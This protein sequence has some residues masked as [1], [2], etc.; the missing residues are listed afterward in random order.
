VLLMAGSGATLR[1]L[2][3]L[4]HADLGY[5]AQNL[6]SVN[7]V[8]REG[9]HD[10]WADRVQYY[11]QIRDAVRG[12]PNVVSAAI[13]FLPPGIFA[14]TPVSVPGLKGASGQAVP[15][16][17]SPEYFAT[18]HIPLLL[19]RTWT[20][21]EAA[22][23]ARLALINQSMRHRYWPD[24]NP[25]GQVFVLNNG[26][27]NANAWK[28]VAPG[29]NQHYQVIGVV[30]DTPN[31]GLDEA[32]APG[33]YIPYSMTAYDGFNI[34]VRSR[35]DPAAL[36]HAIKEHVKG[37][38][39][40]QAVGDFVRAADILEG[41]SLGRERFVASLFSAFA[42]LGLAFAA[43]GLFSIQSYLV[44]QR[45]REL[46]LR[47]ALGAGKSDIVKQITRGSAVAVVLGTVLGLLLTVALSQGFAHWTKG[48][49]REPGMLAIVTIVLFVAAALASAGPALAAASIAPTDALRAE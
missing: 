31:K 28:L 26:I 16:R 38:D 22:Q 18:L 44:A 17:V 9:A 32:V 27:A 36:L 5:E 47:L 4:I 30:G 12:D 15:M 48:D 39:A 11:E 20:K 40:S 25:I 33:L 13:G 1:K 23:G 10:Q 19:G 41:D 46:G 14:S 49:V 45:T 34:V 21:T 6:A 3:Q 43:A 2:S 8:M 35:G 24:T 37:V 29:N 7:L 42:F